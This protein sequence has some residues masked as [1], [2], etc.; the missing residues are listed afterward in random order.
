MHDIEPYYKWRDHY[1][2]ESD[3]R[4]PFYG[5]VYNEFQYTQKVYNYFIHPQWDDFGSQRFDIETTA[6]GESFIADPTDWL[7]IDHDYQNNHENDLHE[8]R[9]SYDYFRNNSLLSYQA[10]CKKHVDWLFR[11]LS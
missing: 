10:S 4:S 5:R 11:S 2:S 8:V 9:K 6:E 7:K 3:D 1:T